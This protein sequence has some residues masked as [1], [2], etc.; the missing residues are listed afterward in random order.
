V[1][2]LGFSISGS[3]VRYDIPL[4]L[5]SAVLAIVVV[6][7]GLFIV[8]FLGPRPVPLLAAGFLTGFG[9]AGMHYVGMAA[10]HTEVDFHYSRALVVLSVW[11]AVAAATVALWFALRVR[12]TYATLGAAL[13]MGAAV[14]GMHYTGMA[15]MKVESMPD[16]EMP[17]G[18]KALEVLAPLIV[19]VSVVTAVL[20]LVI[21]LSRG[22]DDRRIE[23]EIEAGRSGS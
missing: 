23:A 1:A 16:M 21:G 2:M 8:G 15:S 14:T 7:A 9:V 4:T 22:E 19:V 12:G 5:A 3:P 11:I 6:G 13:I 18:A 10:M 17:S 20:L